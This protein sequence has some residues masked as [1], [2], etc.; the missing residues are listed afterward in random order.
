MSGN[1]VFFNELHLNIPI[2]EDKLY[3]LL[4]Y[5]TAD[6]KLQKPDI[7]HVTSIFQPF[8]FSLAL[9]V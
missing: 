6:S 8:I 5:S 2:F 3:G 4:N 7:L 1:V 9:P